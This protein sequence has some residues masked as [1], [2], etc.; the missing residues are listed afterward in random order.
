MGGVSRVVWRLRRFFDRLEIVIYRRSNPRVD[1]CLC[2]EASLA[3]AMLEAMSSC[4]ESSVSCSG[5]GPGGS[6]WRE[7][8]RKFC[9]IGEI[10]VD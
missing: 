2:L 8:C 6:C 5:V 9:H 10:G 4:L 3:C 7:I 1:G